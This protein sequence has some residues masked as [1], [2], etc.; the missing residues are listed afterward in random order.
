MSAPTPL[1]RR[2]EIG[3]LVVHP[4]YRAP[5]HT[6][7]YVALVGGVLAAWILAERDA[8]LGRNLTGDAGGGSWWDGDGSEE[9][10]ES[11]R[12][13]APRR[14]IPILL[15]WEGGISCLSL[16]RATDNRCWPLSMT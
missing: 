7:S 10:M 9:R 13:F 8:A 12:R 15:R 2:H 11:M 14:H 4:P 3:G 1:H 5:H 16:S 6:G